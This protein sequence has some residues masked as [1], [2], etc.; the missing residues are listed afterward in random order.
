MTEDRQG[1]YVY[2]VT[3]AGITLDALEEAKTDVPEVS[4]LEVG[5]L[6]AIVSDAPE[7]DEGATRDAVLAHAQVLASAVKTAPVVPMR[8]GV[9][10]PNDEAVQK[11]LLEDRREELEGLLEKFDSVV[12]MLL[13]VYYREDA[14]LRQLVESEPEIAKLREAIRQGPEDAT[15]NERVRL[16]E[17]VNAAI[18]QR[19]E[20]DAAELMDH[21]K[22]LVV[23]SAAEEIEKELMV[24]N[25]PFLV[26]RGR[27]EEFEGTLDSLAEERLKLMSFKLLGPMPAYHFID[28]EE[29]AWA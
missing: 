27:L 26:E 21:L 14:I 10:F 16:G 23:D 3:R 2:G 4:L 8:F 7:E 5:D 18:E 29:A 15:Y 11:E 20:Q 9:V 19:R 1:T 17:L 24:L 25:A 13:K 28:L 12:E 22:P 6:A